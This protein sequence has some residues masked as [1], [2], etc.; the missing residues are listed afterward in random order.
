M[1]QCWHHHLPPLTAGQPPLTVTQP[2]LSVGPCR[3]QRRQRSP[4]VKIMEPQEAEIIRSI[5]T[6]PRGGQEAE[7]TE[8]GAEDSPRIPVADDS[9]TDEGLGGLGKSKTKPRA[10]ATKTRRARR[11][12]FRPYYQLSEGERGAREARERLRLAKLR[13]RMWAR[14]RII[15]PYNTT[16]FLMAQ[17]EDCYYANAE[18][19][20]NDT[21]FMSN[22]FRKE[23]EVHN[24]N[25][26]EKMSKE[27]LLNEYMI[28]ERKNE[29]LEEKLKTIQVAEEVQEEAVT[30]R[31]SQEQDYANRVHKLQA[32]MEK[33]KMEN[34]R[35][36]AENVA[37][38]RRLNNESESEESSDTESSSGSCSSVSEAVL[39]TIAE[40]TEALRRNRRTIAE[41]KETSYRETQTSDD[42]GYESNQSKGEIK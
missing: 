9:D 10:A 33:L 2:E 11:K 7:T 35:L 13:E 32:E 18:P 28:L 40:D 1:S 25:R 21:D 3:R 31:T 37:M 4:S 24:L 41:D 36:L 38:R 14:G 23:Y 19:P 8:P 20:Q 12:A 29:N 17:T 42:P 5:G 6:G 22:E 15:A 30:G 16:Q 27:M 26:L 39:A 34:E